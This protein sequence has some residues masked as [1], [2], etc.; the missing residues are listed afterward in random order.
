MTAGGESKD[1]GMDDPYKTLG[2]SKTATQDEI[3]AAYRKLAKA[4]HPDAR[5]G[6]KAAEEKFKKVSQAFQI[7]SDKDKRAEYDAMA[8]GG[9]AGM[10]G[11]GGGPGGMGGMGGGPFNFR[12]GRAKAN[13]FEDVSDIFAD[14]FSDPGQDKP[15]AKT[16]RGRDLRHRLELDFIEAAKGGKRR[17]ALGSGKTL[18]IKVPAGADDGQVLRLRGQGERGGDALI[19][20][21]V[22]PHPHFSRDG[23]DVRLELPISL[24][25][26]ALGAKVRAPTIDGPVDVRIP[27][28]SS[29]GALLRLRGKG[30]A[31]ESG[32]RGDQIVR[33][34]V[35]VP[36]RDEALRAFLET[37]TPA[38]GYDPRKG[39]K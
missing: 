36:E 26:A 21:A 7:L 27:P 23:T 11:M 17:I 31:G 4:L 3:R 5:P 19:E 9:F 13:P 30:L 25:E 20:I 29:S 16:R 10:G 15:R 39:M 14:L 1:D 32:G 34:L 24:K 8:A 18:D 2:V 37:W 28:G 35:A 33:L 6:D 38:S 12:Q 22:R